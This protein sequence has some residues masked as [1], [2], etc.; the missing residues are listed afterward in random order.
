MGKVTQV[1]IGNGA[2]A[3]NAARAIRSHDAACQVTMISA[4]NCLAY[5][6]VLLP[7][8]LSGKMKKQEL[9]IAD[10]EFY[11]QNEIELLLGKKVTSIDVGRQTV[12]LSDGTILHY[13]N[14]LV[15]TGGSPKTLNI[16]GGNMAAVMTLR[17][18]EDAERIREASRTARD[19]LI[20]GAGLASLEVANA[21]W[22]KNARMVVMA[23]SPQ[24]LSRN[25]DPECA[26]IMQRDIEK[27]GI[28]FLLESDVSEITKHDGRLHVETDSNGSITV[29][30]VVVGKGVNPNVQFLQGTRIGID[31]GILVNERMQ[32]TIANVYAAGDVAQ[33]RQLLTDDYQII[34]TW[35]SACFEGRIA[36]LNM[37]GQA[38][39]LPPEFGYNIVPIFNRTAA[40]MGES[41]ANS[42]AA[43]I[44]KYCDERKPV[45]RKFLLKDSRVVGAILLESIRDVGTILN[46]I[47]RGVD[48]SHCKGQL[49]SSRI[50]WGRIL[51]EL[52]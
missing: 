26:R 11:R 14:L 4:E 17:T 30:M 19:I 41:R 48:V 36:G 6:P 43:E 34:A 31:R 47:A 45:Y 15:A 1:I 27:A 50:P 42:P 24:I 16:P 46:L 52:S 12:I 33:A 29:D 7:Y 44:F 40:F 35:P 18:I 23:K 20:C 10:R 51:H 39:A 2:A 28:T 13:D 25:A 22:G 3:L 9:F 37:A 49:A 5:S 8:Y 21:L 32:T 38:A